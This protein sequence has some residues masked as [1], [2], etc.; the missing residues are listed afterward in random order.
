MYSFVTT[1]KIILYEEEVY[2]YIKMEEVL[3]LE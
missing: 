2:L 1:Q 3:I